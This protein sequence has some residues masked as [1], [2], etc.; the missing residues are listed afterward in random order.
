MGMAKTCDQ[1]IFF[2]FHHMVPESKM[3]CL[4]IVWENGRR[5]AKQKVFQSIGICISRQMQKVPATDF[6]SMQGKDP[7]SRDSMFHCK[8]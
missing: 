4:W 8:G 2:V 6:S 3:A 1:D 5:T 7:V